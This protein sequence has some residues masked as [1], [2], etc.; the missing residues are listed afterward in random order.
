MK[1]IATWIY[2][3]LPD[4]KRK[5]LETLNIYFAGHQQYTKFV[6]VGYSR[7]GSNF[8][9]AGLASCKEVKMYHEVFADHNRKNGE[10]FD[11]VFNM[12]FNKQPSQVS[13]VGCK[14][15]YFHL[16]E[17]EWKR[18]IDKEGFKIIHLV[19]N[20]KLRTIVSLDIAFKTDQWSSNEDTLITNKR[21]RLDNTTIKKRLESIVQYEQLTRNR[22]VDRAFLEVS[23]EELV[24][25][26]SK[27]FNKISKFLNISCVDV[28]AIELRKQ[29]PDALKDLIENFEDVVNALKGTEY[30]K[31]L[32]S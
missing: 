17:E 27:V 29:N 26:P 30:E 23:Y 19:R 32:I 12:V 8:L 14:I 20:N 10:S 18:F 21:I 3:K 2:K 31:Y 1:R 7:T 5:K 13:A 6:I 22:F 16:T 15:F 9:Y 28:S 25:Y 11:H 24:N 4:E